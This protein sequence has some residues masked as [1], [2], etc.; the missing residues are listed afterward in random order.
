MVPR[1]C[2]VKKEIYEY[3][4][5]LQ[6]EQLATDP[7]IDVIFISNGESQA[8]RNWQQCKKIFGFAKRVD[9]VKGRLASYQAAA[10]LSTSDWFLAVFAKC[11]VLDVYDNIGFGWQ[12]DYW[13][14]SK[15]YI[16]LNKNLETELIYGH[17]APIAYNKKLMLE[18]EGG[19]DMTLA[20]EHVVVPITVSETDLT[21]D[22]WLAW[23]T[24]FREVIKLNYYAEGEL[25]VEG[26]YRLWAWQTK[27][28]EWSQRGA[29]DAMAYIRE[30]GLTEEA[31]MPT[32]EWSWLEAYFKKIYSADITEVITR[33]T[34]LSDK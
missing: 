2:V 23:R 3:P 5:L 9:G 11:R 34:S 15:H 33:S 22:P 6:S 10:N 29:I 20:Q 19:L 26:E 8:D 4:Y 24:A 30:H 12:P 1:D 16:F 18:N 14:Q 25:S 27:G 32:V 28:S 31:V 7:L 13:Q 21:D 17:M